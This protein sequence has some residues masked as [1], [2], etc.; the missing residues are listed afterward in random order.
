MV[1]QY[2]FLLSIETLFLPF[3][4]KMS[5]QSSLPLWVNLILL[6]FLLA[7][8][9]T[10]ISLLYRSAW[11]SYFRRKMKMQDLS[12]IFIYVFLIIVIACGGNYMNSGVRRYINTYNC[13]SNL[14]TLQLICKT[15]NMDN[16]NLPF[17]VVKIRRSKYMFLTQ[18][19]EHIKCWV[20]KTSLSHVSTWIKSYKDHSF[21]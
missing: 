18:H 9:S 4:K 19:L 17:E 20:S 21:F 10:A 2:H 3:L 15:L 6:S 12:L 7:I 8:Y 11:P 16:I 1:Q 5:F 13:I 14:G